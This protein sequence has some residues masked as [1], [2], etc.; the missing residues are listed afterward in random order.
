MFQKISAL[1]LFVSLTTAAELLPSFTPGIG[2]F[3]SE[4][5]AM[6]QLEAKAGP[7]IRIDNTDFP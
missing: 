2:P 7:L 4:E 5:R 6:L 1:L 3:F